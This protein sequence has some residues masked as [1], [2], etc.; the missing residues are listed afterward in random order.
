M[1]RMNQSRR[2]EPLRTLIHAEVPPRLIVGQDRD[3]NAD[4][5]DRPGL[6]VTQLV[7]RREAIRCVGR[8]AARCGQREQCED[9]ES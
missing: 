7:G 8:C 1:L 5:A 6:H 4:V 3:R 2:S 9:G